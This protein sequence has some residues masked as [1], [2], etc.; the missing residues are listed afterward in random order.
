[1]TTEATYIEIKGEV[2]DL[3]KSAHVP[4]FH[5]FSNTAMLNKIVFMNNSG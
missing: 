2:T 4:D 1:M 3:G 5:A